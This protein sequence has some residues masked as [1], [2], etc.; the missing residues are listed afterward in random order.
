MFNL[1]RFPVPASLAA[2]SG[3]S[4]IYEES[5]FKS[6]RVPARTLA[7]AS[8]HKNRPVL[9]QL[10]SY[11]MDEGPLKLIA[12]RQKACFLIDLSYLINSYGTARAIRLSRL[13]SFL[14]SCVKYGA[15]YALCDMARGEKEMRTA[16]ELIHIG[17]LVGLNAGQSKMAMGM[18]GHYV[19]GN[20]DK[21]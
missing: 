16:R 13:R 6:V 21:G 10:E 4:K 12:E 18:M 19:N 2:R 9:L 17:L 20:Q 7:E 8:N 3:Y 1:V 11:D 5:G 15:R 14:R